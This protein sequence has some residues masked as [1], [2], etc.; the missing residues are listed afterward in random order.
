MM[1]LDAALRRFLGLET[2]YDRRIL[3]A[4][5]L[6]AAYVSAWAVMGGG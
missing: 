6:S 4:L 2:R 3:A 5:A 1:A